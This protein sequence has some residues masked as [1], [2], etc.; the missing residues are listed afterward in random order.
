MLQN[1]ESISSSA[2]PQY[3]VTQS[4]HNMNVIGSLTNSMQQPS[5]TRWCH[6]TAHALRSTACK[7]QYCSAC[8]EHRARQ[9]TPR[10]LYRLADCPTRSGKHSLCFPRARLARY[11]ATVITL[12][13]PAQANPCIHSAL[14]GARPMYGA[15]PQAAAAAYSVRYM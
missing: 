4:S 15:I 6:H 8:H 5:I 2:S 13:R 1:R 9:D 3:H 10:V 7:Q 11:R 12:D 14:R